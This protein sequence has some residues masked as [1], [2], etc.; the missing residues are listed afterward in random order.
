MGCYDLIV[1]DQTVR[2]IVLANVMQNPS[3]DVDEF[4]DLKGSYVGR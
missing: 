4:F 3:V 2:F 1:Y